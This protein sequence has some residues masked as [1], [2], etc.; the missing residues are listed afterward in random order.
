MP[1]TKTISKQA[2]MPPKV[3]LISASDSSGAAGLQADLA[4]CH[5]LSVHPVSVLTAVTAQHTQG[6]DLIDPVDP[7]IMKNQFSSVFRDSPPVCCKIGLVANKNQAKQIRQQLAPKSEWGPGLPVIWDP[8]LA[9]TTGKDFHTDLDWTRQ[10]Y[11]IADIITPNIQEAER[12]TGCFIQSPETMLE[13]AKQLQSRGLKGVWLKGGHLQLAEFPGKAVDLFCWADHHYWLVQDRMEVNYSRGTGCTLSTALAAFIAL[14]GDSADQPAVFDDLTVLNAVTLASAYVHQGLRSGYPIGPGGGPIARLQ[15]PMEY[16]DYPH[17][18]NRLDDMSIALSPDCGPM[19]LGL[20]PVVE[21][22]DWLGKLLPLGITTV[23]LRVKDKTQ[24]ELESIIAAAVK[25]QNQFNT[26]LFINDHWQLAIKLGAY[27][28]HLGQED[29]LDADLQLIKDAGL[30]IG[31][32]THG[33]FEWARAAALK[34]SYLAIGA[35]YPTTTK[36]VVVV[37]EEK[38]GL[39]VDI[40]KPHFPLTAIGGISASNIDRVLSTGMDSVA[41]VSAIT[42]AENYTLATER[43]MDFF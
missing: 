30:R 33:E 37:G 43:L 40:L 32:S 25:L 34:P 29:I 10:L 38:L 3:L 15:W 2:T 24:K 21:S 13:A 42:G 12:L 31:I 1:I 5:G 18:F 6:V 39:W 8:V 16:T 22:V 19:P 36:E 27:G 23:Q 11:P 9:S 20:Y 41:L 26:R 7:L 28:V 35:I 14:R 4:A 17:I